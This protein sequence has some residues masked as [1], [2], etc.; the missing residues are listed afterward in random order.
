MRNLLITAATAALA[1]AAASPALAQTEGAQFDG[2]YVSASIGYSVQKN[3]IQERIFF[4]RNGDGQFG[5][6]ITTSAGANAFSP[7][8]CNGAVGQNRCP[9]DDDA[10]DYH[11]RVGFDRPIGNFVVGALAE[12]GKSEVRDA[13]SAFSTTPAYYTMEREIDWEG[14]LRARAGYAAGGRTLFYVTGGPSYAKIDNSFR[15]SNTANAFSDNGETES[16]GI[17]GG[18]GVETLIGRNLSFG[19]EY[20]HHYYWEDDYRVRAERGSAPATNPFVLGSSGTDF[21]RSNKD[22]VWHSLRATVGF[23]F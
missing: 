15:T 17:T 1:A 4:D 6:T 21:R 2:P 22:F 16:W 13:V 10:V 23:R 18:G 7:G 8:F 3:D 19:L 12:F 11:V 5:D 20:I 14:S 9:N